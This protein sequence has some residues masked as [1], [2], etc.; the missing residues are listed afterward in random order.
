MGLV[1]GVGTNDG[2]AS[3]KAHMEHLKVH[4]YFDIVIGV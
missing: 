3:A 4:H 2:E 1:L